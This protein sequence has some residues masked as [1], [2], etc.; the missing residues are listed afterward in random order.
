MSLK[1]KQTKTLK[2]RKGGGLLGPYYY[3]QLVRCKITTYRK[4]YKQPGTSHR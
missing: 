1:L 2:P 4:P 3:Q